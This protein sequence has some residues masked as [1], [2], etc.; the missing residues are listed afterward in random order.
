MLD[1]INQ[2]LARL[3][4]AEKQVAEWVLAHPRQATEATVAE[5]ARECAT[6]EPTVI[7][8]CRRMGL[9]GFRELTIR[10]TEALSRP[11]SFVHHDVSD[12]DATSDATAK[13][14]DAAIQSLIEARSQ[15]ST[16]PFDE[17]IEAMVCAR[18]FVFAGLGASGHVAGDACHKLFRLGTPCSALT[19]TPS[20]RQ[21]AS[22]AGPGDV[23]FVIS[24]TGQSPE[25]CQA[26][27][28]AMN[29][30]AMVVAVTERN[31]ELAG[32]ARYVFACNANEDTNIY[33][34]MSSRLVHL[35][36]LD[37]LQVALALAIGETAATNLRRSKDALAADNHL[38]P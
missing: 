21:F 22:I 37:A 24:K 6:S 16:V 17:V 35:A 11:D 13:V 27:K 25:L 32:A 7:R 18:Q 5:V 2:S 30:G 34:P 19:D 26:A 29:N 15:L 10:L 31:S 9:N 3:S 36:L 28:Q 23:L 8:F 20:I 38:L 14:V 1:Q 33:T 12:D 4:R